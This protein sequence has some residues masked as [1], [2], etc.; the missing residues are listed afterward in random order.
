MHNRRNNCRLCE[1]T[2]LSCVLPLEPIL[3]GEHYLNNPSKTKELR[4]P[5][6]IYQC[7]KC[8]AVQTLDDIDPNYLWKD[9][10]YF[11]G[12]TNGIID[13]FKDFSIN[14]LHKFNLGRKLMFWILVVMMVLY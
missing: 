7:K 5:I 11:S 1:S 14:I 4:F 10:T 12:Q 3:L 8:N 2:N 9:Y 6:D 13:H